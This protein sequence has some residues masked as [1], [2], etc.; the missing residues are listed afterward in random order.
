MLFRSMIRGVTELTRRIIANYGPDKLSDEDAHLEKVE[1]LTWRTLPT[2]M[3]RLIADLCPAN[4]AILKQAINA[5]S[6]PHPAQTKKNDTTKTQPGDTGSAESGAGEDDVTNGGADESPVGTDGTDGDTTDGEATGGGVGD[7][8]GRRAG[9]AFGL[10]HDDDDHDDA[11]GDHDQD[12]GDRDD[13]WAYLKVRDERS[14]AK[15]RVD[16]LMDLVGAGAK[17]ACGDGVS[18]GATATVL[19]TMDLHKL[20][21]DLDGAITIGGEIL[22]AGTARRL[23]CD[24]DLIP[25]VLGTKSQHL[26]VGRRYRLATKGIRAA[27]VH[28]D[29]GCSFP[30]CDRPPGFCAVHHVLPWWAGGDTSLANSAMLCARHH[31]IVHRHGYYATITPDGVTWDLTEAAMPGWQANKVA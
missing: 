5:L 22:D 31:Q 3:I 14:P 11:D 4:A 2:G 10:D 17:V 20:L 30:G 18:I 6:A 25:I 26:D 15:R 28:R 21:G 1:S 9:A 19:V 29:L 27:V 8:D 24:A 16:A 23:A 12:D 7:H 13:R